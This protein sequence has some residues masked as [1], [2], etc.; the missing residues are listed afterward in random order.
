VTLQGFKYRIYPNKEQSELL[1]KTFGCVRFVYNKILNDCIETF[2]Q[3]KK[4]KFNQPTAYKEEFPWL[5]EIDSRALSNAR[6]DLQTAYNNFFR[7]VKNKEAKKGFPKFKSKKRSKS[8][9][10]TN[11]QNRGIRI[12]KNKVGIPK[13]GFTKIKLHRSF[14]GKIKSAT[15]SRNPSGKYFTS[16]LVEMDDKNATQKTEDKVLGIDMS[17]RNF[18]VLSTGEKINFNF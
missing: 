18:A 3:T 11:N 10:R 2:K 13:V 12:R 15:V 14:T 4:S 7:K 16:L 1:N 6:I 8:S 5:K 17:F 9:Y